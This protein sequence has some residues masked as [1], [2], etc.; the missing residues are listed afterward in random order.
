MRP[1]IPNRNTTQVDVP[2]AGPNLSDSITRISVPDVPPRP[3]PSPTYV[4]G[5]SA[6][7]FKYM[8]RQYSTLP[9]SSFLFLASSHVSQKWA[10]RL[11]FSL[12]GKHLLLDLLSSHWSWNDEIIQLLSK[13]STSKENTDFQ[14]KNNIQYY[15]LHTNG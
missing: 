12:L 2:H 13:V 11:F 8:V 3:P 14:L 9:K 6:Y 7:E 15:K 5:Y 10:L 1:F 4:P